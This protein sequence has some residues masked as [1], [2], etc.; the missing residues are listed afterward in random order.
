VRKHPH[1]R[2]SPRRNEL[3]IIGPSAIA[4]LLILNG[5]EDWIRTQDRLGFSIGY[6]FCIAKGA[7]CAA[8]SIG[9]PR[10][11][12]YPLNQLPEHTPCLQPFS[13]SEVRL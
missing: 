7:I 3:C 9:G 5:Y 10:T 8:G 1:R 11:A 12:N 13:G 4:Q 6:R 2:E